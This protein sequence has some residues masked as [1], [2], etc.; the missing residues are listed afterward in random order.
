MRLGVVSAWRAGSSTGISNMALAVKV[1]S[2]FA[3]FRRP[4]THEVKPPTI[5]FPISKSGRLDRLLISVNNGFLRF[6][7]SLP[8]VKW[9]PFSKCCFLLESFSARQ[10]LSRQPISMTMPLP[11][12]GGFSINCV[13]N[14]YIFC[15]L[16]VQSGAHFLCIFLGELDEKR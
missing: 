13:K 12:G 14:F 16:L 10:L 15:V 5:M 8:V 1:P 3:I 9:L 7:F 2:Q 6:T 11:I 4:T